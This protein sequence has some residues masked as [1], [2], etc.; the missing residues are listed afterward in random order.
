MT[1]TAPSVLVTAV[2]TAPFESSVRVC[3][4]VASVALPRTS[5]LKVERVPEEDGRKIRTIGRSGP[6]TAFQ[7]VTL[8][9]QMS[10][11]CW[12]VRLVT[13]VTSLLVTT[14]QP[15]RA[16]MWST[17]LLASGVDSLP[18]GVT[19]ESPI[20]MEPPATCVRP[21]PEPPPLTVIVEPGQ[22]FTYCL[23]AASTSGWRAVDPAAVML[24]VTQLIVGAAAGAEA[25]GVAAGVAAVDAAVDGAAVG[26]RVGADVE[27][28]VGDA[29]ADEHAAANIIAAMAKPPRRRVPLINVVS[30]LCWAA[31]RANLLPVPRG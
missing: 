3:P 26:A 18:T 13:P 2:V 7:L 14:I 1:L 31:N 17:R 19:S 30:P 11:F 16:M 27:A 6:P 15:W 12:V 29:P 22:A 10:M 20:W 25:A 5:F 21:V 9:V 24:P 4:P 28:G 23:A 8:P